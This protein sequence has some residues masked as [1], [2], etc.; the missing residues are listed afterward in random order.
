MTDPAKPAVATNAVAERKS[1]PIALLQQ[2]VTSREAEFARALPAHVP[3]P[4]FVRTLLTAITSSKDIAACTERSVVMEC[5]KAAADGLV[6]DNREA[7]LVKMNVNIGTKENKKWEAQAKY[8][9]MYAGLMKMA[10]N[11]GEIST[12]AAIMVHQND[13]F[14]YTP[15]LDDMP[16]HKIDWFGERGA[17][18]GVYAVVK[19]K[20]GSSIVEVLSKAQVLKIGNNTKNAHQYDIE[21][22]ESYGEWWRKTAI[23]RISKYLP[24]STD[25]ERGDFFEAVRRDDD[26]YEAPLGDEPQDPAKPPRKKRGAAQAAL[27]NAPPAAATADEIPAFLD[28]RQTASEV[29]V[30]EGEF[31]EAD[32]RPT[33]PPDDLI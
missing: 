2:A 28:R 3:A 7:T 26:L 10:R 25:K 12:I 9:P 1:N 19:L 29:E 16:L 21:K 6:I 23:R 31:E 22:G 4:K 11:S 32:G 13:T 33:P 5:M 14:D 17:P 27:D 24:R 30:I 15:G 18:I 8:I 20:D